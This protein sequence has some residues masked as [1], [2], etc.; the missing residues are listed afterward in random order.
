MDMFT[1]QAKE[2]RVLDTQHRETGLG[3][4]LFESREAKGWSQER[5]SAESGV[6]RVTISKWESGQVE[7]PK[8]G[9]T[10]KLADA[11]GIPTEALL[12]PLALAPA[13][14]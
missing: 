4:A 9:T 12:R 13:T 2:E 11:L 10:R 6:S 5:L 14:G 7:T 3:R 1:T 8:M